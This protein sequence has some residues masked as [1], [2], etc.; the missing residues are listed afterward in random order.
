MLSRLLPAPVIGVLTFVTM[1]ALLLMLT[2]ALMLG[3]A[4]KALVPASAVRRGATAAL[5][6]IADFWVQV[7]ALIYRLLQDVRW[8]VIVEGEI[9]PRRGYLLVC[10]HQ[11]WADILVLCDAFRG[12]TFFPRFFLKQA[13]IWVPI[14]G[15]VCW[16]LDM[17]FMR[18]HS[19][20]AVARNPRL[21]DDDLRAT[22]A[23]CQ[24]YRWQPI[25]A[26]MFPEGTRFTASKR[27]QKQSP[28]RHLMRP[29]AGGL[30]FMIDAMGDQFAG[31]ID[32]TIAYRSTVSED[33]LLW[34]W[35]CGRQPTLIV[36]AQV[37][38]VPVLSAAADGAP[39]QRFQ[40]WVNVLWA[41][42]D[43]RLERLK[44]LTDEGAQVST[45]VPH[46]G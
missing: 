9:D 14:V 27:D 44:S 16:A 21:R 20:Q 29:K 34:S 5:V 22:R 2:P 43:A 15:I 35:L 24:K 38:P 4:I 32:V 13:L 6:A 3:V 12:R 45:Q 30:A 40:D 33:G 28:F 26:V 23:F 18:R 10:N 31:L 37:Q 8:Q 19:P 7:D 41:Q 25:S 42:K 36:H 17:P 1:L 11:S 46:R 39:R